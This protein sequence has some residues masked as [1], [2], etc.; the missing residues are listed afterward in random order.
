MKIAVAVTDGIVSQ[1]FGHCE[2]FKIYEVDGDKV[3]NSIDVDNPGHRPGF[4]PVFLHD[5]GADM[6]VAGGMGGAA[7]DLFKENGIKVIVGASGNPDT[8]IKGVIDGSIKSTGT[9]CQH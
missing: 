2:I 8:V 5:Q 4:L 7:Q 9:V 3:V 6:I 1:H